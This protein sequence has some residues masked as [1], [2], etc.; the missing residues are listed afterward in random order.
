ML[1]VVFFGVLESRMIVARVQ[2]VCDTELSRVGDKTHTIFVSQLKWL[3]T[4]TIP[5]LVEGWHGVREFIGRPRPVWELDGQLGCSPS[6]T[7]CLSHAG[8]EHLGSPWSHA[9]D[10]PR[11]ELAHVVCT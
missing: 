3:A 5:A 6:D 9:Q 4:R 8:P 10:A 7:S 2:R 1:F 11:M